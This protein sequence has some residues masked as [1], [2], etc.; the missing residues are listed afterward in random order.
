MT[1][2]GA[3]ETFATRFI[4]VD[5]RLSAFLAVLL[6]PL[7]L[8]RQAPLQPLHMSLVMFLA[9]A[10]DRCQARYRRMGAI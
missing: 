3:P 5:L 8:I 10:A 7:L 2:P 1:H 6:L 9:A 4:A